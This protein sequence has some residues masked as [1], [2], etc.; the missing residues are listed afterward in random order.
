MAGTS[1]S[2]MNEELLLSCIECFISV[3]NNNE[4]TQKRR[5]RARSMILRN[6]G[7]VR[8]FLDEDINVVI[9]IDVSFD[10][11]QELLPPF[12]CV[13]IVSDL[14]L[15]ESLHTNMILPFVQSFFTTLCAGAL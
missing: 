13:P 4:E 10:H 11:I 6:G 2:F 8:D 7:L 15:Q 12:S 14:W 3:G 5:E 1:V 9:G